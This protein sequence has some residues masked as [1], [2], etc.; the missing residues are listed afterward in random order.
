MRLSKT[1]TGCIAAACMAAA[2]FPGTAGAEVL[3][4]DAV[5]LSYEIKDGEPVA[6]TEM[7]SILSAVLFRAQQFDE[8]AEIYR[9]SEK[10]IS[11]CVSDSVDLETLRDELTRPADLSFELEDGTQVISGNLSI[12]DAN[13]FAAYLNAGTSLERLTEKNVLFLNNALQQ[14]TV[15][16]PA[17]GRTVIGEFD[18]DGSLMART[19]WDAYGAL[20]TFM[21]HS[22]VTGRI[23][24]QYCD[25]PEPFFLYTQ[26][27]RFEFEVGMTRLL[28]SADPYFQ[29]Y[30]ISALAM[31]RPLQTVPAREVV[32]SADDVP[33]LVFYYDEWGGLCRV[34]YGDDLENEILPE[35]REFKDPS[36]CRII[37]SRMRLST[38]D[39]VELSECVTIKKYDVGGRLVE[40][41][42]EGP[43]SMITENAGQIRI[44][45]SYT[46]NS[47]GGLVSEYRTQGDNVRKT[48]YDAAG[49][50]VSARFEEEGSWQCIYLYDNESLTQICWDVND[51]W[52]EDEDIDAYKEIAE[53]I[54]NAPENYPGSCVISRGED[55]D[56]TIVTGLP[57]QTSVTVRGRHGVFQGLVEEEKTIRR[58]DE[59]GTGYLLTGVI[60]SIDMFGIKTGQETTETRLD[61]SGNVTEEETAGSTAVYSRFIDTYE[62]GRMMRAYIRE[63]TDEA[64]LTVL[65]QSVIRDYGLFSPD[66]YMLY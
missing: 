36:G 4:K 35:K 22:L 44:S 14:I 28:E 30:Y 19:E 39:P 8:G 65:D 58:P 51:R 34:C 33:C 13:E 45:C 21:D 11:V 54:G 15:S 32:C 37:E 9:D 17:N 3:T 29:E 43:E 41:S 40:Y 2:F 46:R 60:S 1:V 49:R 47:S 16:D 5:L 38:D 12:D 10:E 53:Q 50:V 26:T 6:E 31:G 7:D 62:T 48:R 25:E 59:T 55:N 66:P 64:D 42:F 63:E 24:E 23:I 52:S 57:D 56:W 27:D 20:S 18:R 61:G